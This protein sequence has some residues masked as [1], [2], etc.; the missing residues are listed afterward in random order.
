MKKIVT[1]GISLV[2]TAMLSASIIDWDLPNLTTGRGEPLVPSV[3]NIV[4]ILTSESSFDRESGKITTDTTPT[5]ISNNV[6]LDGTYAWGTW[7]DSNSSGGTY[8]MTFYNDGNYYALDNGS[9]DAITVV[10]SADNP[11]ADSRVPG[12][13]TTGSLYLAEDPRFSSSGVVKT[14]A[15]QVPEPATAAL[16]LAGLALL[17][18]RRRTV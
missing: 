2:S 13:E 6:K 18:R 11:N 7:K 5:P 16:A 4:F 3:D 15:P 10:A 12:A 8:Y 17:I 9:R 1:F 14:I